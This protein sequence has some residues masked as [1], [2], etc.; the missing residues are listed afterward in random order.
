M[1]T[2]LKY[3]IPLGFGLVVVAQIVGVILVFGKSLGKGLLSVVVPGYFIFALRREGLYWK[4]VGAWL[5]G[6]LFIVA[7]TL[8]YS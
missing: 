8:V 5:L 4:V 7:G 2:V 1:E 6:I 3:L